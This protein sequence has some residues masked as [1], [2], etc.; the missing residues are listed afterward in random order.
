M[1]N[2]FRAKK[3]TKD[4]EAYL[5]FSKKELSNIIEDFEDDT[6]LVVS[7][8]PARSLNKN[9]TFH[10][11]VRILAAHTGETFANMKVQLV[12]E[13]FGCVEQVI[14]GKLYSIPVS[15]ADV[16][17][18]EFSNALTGIYQWAEEYH[19]ITLPTKL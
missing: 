6:E 14:N 7:V 15:T 10:G 1:K 4:K 2:V 3:K 16:S 13:F 9:N 19:N 18:E 5:V 11:W 12:C 17:D 8:D